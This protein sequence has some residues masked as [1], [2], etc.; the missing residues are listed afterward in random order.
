MD[1]SPHDLP[2]TIPWHHLCALGVLLA[3]LVTLAVSPAL[4]E[5]LS[6]QDQQAIES[7]PPTEEVPAEDPLDDGAVPTTQDQ[8]EKVEEAVPI[9]QNETQAPTAE[10]TG[11]VEAPA[12]ADLSM[13]AH[14]SSVGWQTPVDR[15]AGQDG[16]SH[17]LE[18][19]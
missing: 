19:L 17:H 1:R 3:C 16:G 13:R 5:P 12:Q 11:A 2:R 10:T 9:P 8:D 14:V 18:A 15:V 4:A 6:D 7:A